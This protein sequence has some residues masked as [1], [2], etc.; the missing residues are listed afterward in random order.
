MLNAGYRSLLEFHAVLELGPDGTIL[1]ASAG[2]LDPLGLTPAEVLGKPE[3]MLIDLAVADSDDYAAAWAG[4]DARKIQRLEHRVTASDGSEHWIESSY[5]PIHDRQGRLRLVVKLVDF[6]T[7]RKLLNADHAGQIQ[8]I[9]KSQAVVEFAMD[10]TILWANDLFL[11]PIG[12]SLDEVEGRH[13]SM[14]V[15][16]EH[17][18][19]AE[20]R[21][22]WDSLGAGRYQ[23]AEY[24]RIG[25]G[26]REV[27]IQAS[28]TPI[29]DLSGKPFKVVKYAT[30]VTEPK[31]VAADHASQV[32]A[33]GLSQAVVEF[34]TD[35]IVLSANRRFLDQMGYELEEVQGRHHRMFIDRGETDTAAYEAFWRA[36]NRGEYQA[37]EFKRVRKDGSEHWIQAFYTPILDLNGRPFKIVKYAAFVTDQVR[38]RNELQR[39]K[40][41]VEESLRELAAAKAKVEVEVATQ[42]A[43]SQQLKAARDEAETASTAKSA[44]LAT[45]SHEFRTPLNAII[46]F[47]ELIARQIN[48]AIGDPRYL[49]YSRHILESGTHLSALI[50]DM[51]DISAIEAGRRVYNSEPLDVRD[52]VAQCVEKLTPLAERGGISLVS[53]HA[54]EIPAILADRRSVIQIA[55]NILSNAIKYSRPNG[56]VAVRLWHEGPR[57]H[58]RISDDGLGIPEDCLA[59]ITEP[60]TR[61]ECDA[62]LARPGTGLGLAIVKSLVDAHDGTL[63][64]ESRLGEGTAVTVSLPVADAD[65]PVAA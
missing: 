41:A 1:H 43:L 44:F 49:E 9:A 45:M 5:T 55:T 18:E 29:L 60:F 35:G 62:H 14:L 65:G 21:E 40:R 30:F 6:V 47:S 51:L 58:I 42:Q 8:A 64:I 13:H 59:D 12:Y 11:G 26:G 15:D 20:Y 31:L 3:R 50:D 38:A 34:T 32:A 16:P 53:E 57:L 33:I 23:T 63:S 25:K 61:V 56:R 10:G 2:Y 7:D 52:L 17:A 54:G 24:K 4:L 46:G 27:W 19:G 28:Y 39:A 37:G 36:L 48:G 22:F